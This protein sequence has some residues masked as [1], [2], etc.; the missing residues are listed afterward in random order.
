MERDFSGS[1]L[2]NTPRAG[3]KNKTG[4]YICC[5]CGDKATNYRSVRLKLSF[6][7]DKIISDFMEPP[8]SATLVE[9]SSRGLWKKKE[10]LDAM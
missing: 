3:S 1:G 2:N 4:D 8:M 6:S 7:S 9:F 10:S 5:V